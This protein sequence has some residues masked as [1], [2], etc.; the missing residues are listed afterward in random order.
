MGPQ[1]W[2]V[3]LATVCLLGAHSAT[4]DFISPSSLEPRRLSAAN[5]PSSLR[6]R[7]SESGLFTREASFDF[8]EDTAKYGDS[9]FVST[10]AVNSQKPILALED[11]EDLAHIS[12]S[13]SWIELSFVSIERL[14]DV[15]E[16]L[17]QSSDFIAVTSHPGCNG[18]GERASHK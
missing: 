11:I 14:G 8:I 15:K 9:S 7:R 3:A 1:S 18:D 13:D 17:S 4:A 5:V 16:E 12:C 6:S 10:V 2:P